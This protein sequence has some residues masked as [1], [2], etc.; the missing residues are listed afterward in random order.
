[1]AAH[2]SGA[3]ALSQATATRV[4]NVDIGGGTTKLALI[5]NGDILATIAIAVGGR[6]IVEDE[7]GMTRIEEPAR[8]VAH[9]LG[10]DLALGQRCRR[11][12][13]RASWSAW[14]GC[15]CA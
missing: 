14:S 8:D 12:T 9:S 10:I 1:M 13:A 6:L 7:A 11:R 2:G 3:V 4:L 15:S 5:E